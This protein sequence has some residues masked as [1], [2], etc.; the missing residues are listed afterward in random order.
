M[1]KNKLYFYSK[2]IY[3]RDR[4]VY[5]VSKPKEVID[6][7]N[8]EHIIRI[9]IFVLSCREHKFDL[10]RQDMYSDIS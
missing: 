8:D 6:K 3:G 9:S 1:F 5:L 4:L 7:D 2:D 10:K